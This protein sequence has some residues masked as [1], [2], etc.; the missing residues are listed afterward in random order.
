M[1]FNMQNT[2][3]P[4]NLIIR[5]IT[6][7]FFPGGKGPGGGCKST[8]KRLKYGYFKNGFQRYNISCS[9]SLF[10]C[11]IGF[12]RPVKEGFG[13]VFRPQWLGAVLLFLYICFTL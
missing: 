8:C 5:D 6:L 12:Q 2:V 4:N 9:F 10:L 3:K 11:G 13:P 7:F 1:K